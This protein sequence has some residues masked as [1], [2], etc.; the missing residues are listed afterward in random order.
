[1]ELKYLFRRIVAI[2]LI[3]ALLSIFVSVVLQKGIDSQIEQDKAM[4]ENHMQV[5]Q[6]K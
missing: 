4:W 5:H 6:I 3:M 1:M 2:A